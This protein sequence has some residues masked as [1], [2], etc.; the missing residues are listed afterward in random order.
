MTRKEMITA[1]REVLQERAIINEGPGKDYLDKAARAY[2]QAKD[3][4][5]AKPKPN[6]NDVAAYIGEAETDE[7]DEH[8]LS[9]FIKKGNYK[10]VQV[11]EYQ[12]DENKYDFS[13]KAGAGEYDSSIII[14]KVV[15]ESGKH[16]LIPGDSGKKSYPYLST[17]DRGILGDTYPL[18]Q[19]EHVEKCMNYPDSDNV[20]NFDP[21]NCNFDSTLLR[22]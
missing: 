4:E 15:D 10:E 20:P 7:I 16:I 6:P 14:F 17:T 5:D 1:L 2:F 13:K 21:F 12:F 22:L 8:V 18:L 11:A 9:D 19:A 3:F